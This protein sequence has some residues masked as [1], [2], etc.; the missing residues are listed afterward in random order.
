[1]DQFLEADYFLKTCQWRLIPISSV[2][3]STTE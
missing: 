3:T 1:L 2:V